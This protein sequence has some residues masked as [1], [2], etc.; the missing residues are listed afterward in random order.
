MQKKSLCSK[1]EATIFVARKGLDNFDENSIAYENV[2]SMSYACSQCGALMFKG[3]KSGGSLSGEYPTA[4]FSLCC[5]NGEI[6]L[7]LIK[8]PPEKLKCLLTGNTKK[9]HDFRTNIRGYNSSLAF[10]SM[11]VSGEECKFKTNGPYCYRISSQVY[12][13]LSQMEPESGRRPSFSQIYI[14]DQE[15]ELDNRLHSFQKFDRT[16]LKELQDIIKAV[17][18]YAQL[19]KHAGDIMM[20]NP[21]QDVKLVL[22][23]HDEKSNIDPHRYNLPT[24]RFSCYTSSG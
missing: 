18:S 4:K 3:E 6:K 14:Y 19:Y 20:E 2:G 23:A 8:E 13:A 12:H 7:P 24:G 10:A 15:H 21:S 5:S 22:R 11:C 16:V 9:D 1:T 17:N